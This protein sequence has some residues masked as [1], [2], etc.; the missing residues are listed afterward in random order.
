MESL[1]HIASTILLKEKA[2]MMYYSDPSDLPSHC[3]DSIRFARV[4]RKFNKALLMTLLM[5]LSAYK[6]RTNV[7]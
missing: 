6:L 2:V 4:C 5:T 1:I 3:K 7:K